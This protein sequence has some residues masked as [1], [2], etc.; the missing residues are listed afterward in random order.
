MLLHEFILCY[1]KPI[2]LLETEAMKSILVL[3]L[4]II[5]TSGVYAQG[6]VSPKASFTP[7]EAYQLAQKK[8]A[9]LIDVREQTEVA[10]KAYSAKNVV[11]IPLGEL[12]NRLAEI[13][14]NKQVI[15]LCRSGN[16]SQRAYLFLK[17]KGYTNVANMEGGMNG[18]AAS[19]L[20]TKSGK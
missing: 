2:H 17:G 9:I 13:P 7:Q 1:Q 12:P 20:P 15:M 10:E 19:N 16:R 18:W 6:F 3:L 5:G 4:L 8:K 14:K 11:N